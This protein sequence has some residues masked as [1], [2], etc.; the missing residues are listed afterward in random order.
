M[1]VQF[2][3]PGQ[4]SAWARWFTPLGTI[5]VLGYFGFHAFNGQYGVRAHI[6]FAAKEAQLVNE[7]TVLQEQ[8]E[9]LEARVLLLRDGSMEA[10]MVADRARRTLNLAREDEVLISFE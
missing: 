10:D 3:R 7:L 6:A 1:A 9:R 4:R 5:A 2:R 8:R